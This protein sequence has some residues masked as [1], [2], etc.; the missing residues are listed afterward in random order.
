MQPELRAAAER[1]RRGVYNDNTIYEGIDHT[2]ERDDD[3]RI[4]ATAYLRDNLAD[5]SLPIDPEWLKSIGFKDCDVDDYLWMLVKGQDFDLQWWPKAGVWLCDPDGAIEVKGITT[6]GALRRLL[7]AL[8]GE[9][10]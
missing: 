7:K 2:K 1:L 9:S 4:L 5:D 6:R 10:K 8:T 3:R